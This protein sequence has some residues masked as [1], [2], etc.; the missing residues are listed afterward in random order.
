MKVFV[1]Y[2]KPDRDFAF[3]LTDQLIKQGHEAWMADNVLFPGDNWP[4]AIGRALQHSD[5]MVVLLSRN[6]G[7]S[8]FQRHEIN[9]ALGSERY[10]GRVIPVFI[11]PTKD[12]PWILDEFPKVQAIQANANP[13]AVGRKIGQLLRKAG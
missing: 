10:S 9:F 11:G 2:A 1:S 4:L 12:Y 8:E 6:S 13:A 5:A 3:S 7:K